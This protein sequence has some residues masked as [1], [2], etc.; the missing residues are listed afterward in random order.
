MALA[1]VDAVNLT[2][3]AVGPQIDYYL[4]GGI[5]AVQ[6]VL[7]AMTARRSGVI[8]VTTGASSGPVIH[9]PLGSVG[10]ATAALR[11]WTLQLHAA[12]EPHGVYAAHVAIAA[13]IGKGG[14]Q[15]QP[16]AIAEAYREL[17]TSR[18]QAELVYRD[19]TLK[20]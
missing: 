14:P 3:E 5:T 7:P 6:A 11:N 10:A 8:V 16:D 20:L 9:P 15:S 12:L 18:T 19:E 2:V 4:H 1:P 17:V 13:Y